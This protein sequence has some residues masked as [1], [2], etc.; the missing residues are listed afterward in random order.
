MRIRSHLAVLVVMG[1]W[2][3]GIA[4]M[5][6]ARAGDWFILAPLERHK[7]AAA[8]DGAV[9][10]LAKE[11]DWLEH[12]IDEY[13]TVVPKQPDIWGQARLTAHRAEFDAKMQDELGIFTETLQAS[14]RVSDQAFFGMAMALSKGGADAS[15]DWSKIGLEK[16]TDADGKTST[17]STFVR[18]SGSTDPLKLSLE[19][20]ARVAQM[21]R[22]LNYVNELRRI[23]EGDD[24]A[25]SPGYAMY[26]LR[27]P[28][29]VLPGKKT[30]Q[31][32]GAEITILAEPQ[33]TDDLLPTTFRNLVINDVV[34]QLSL[35][36]T[37]LLN[38]YQGDET[39]WDQLQLA[40]DAAHASL[41][42]DR[43]QEAHAGD[44]PHTAEYAQ[45]YRTQL[46]EWCANSEQSEENVD[47]AKKTQP[48]SSSA[49][50]A[51]RTGR[52]FVP[53]NESPLVSR[54]KQP[55]ALNRTE[56]V[57]TAAI[58]EKNTRNIRLAF[59][60]LSKR[61]STLSTRHSR[62]AYPPTQ[63][64]ELAGGD[65][66]LW[67]PVLLNARNSIR[68]ATQ[69]KAK[70]HLLD[71]QAFLRAELEAAYE[72]L[73]H[74]KMLSVW[75][76]CCT[77]DLVFAAR[78]RHRGGWTMEGTP[79]LS[80][81]T[82][83]KSTQPSFV[84]TW[85][86]YSSHLRRIYADEVD[87][88][89]NLPMDLPPQWEI[90]STAMVH[91]ARNTT[92]VSL[93]WAILVE[94]TL[95]N[96]R[97]IDDIRKTSGVRGCNPITAEDWPPFY[98]PRNPLDG[99]GHASCSKD[100]EWPEANAAF[101]QYVRC[102]WP[103]QVF[104]LDPITDEQNVADQYQGHRELQVAVA[105]AVANGQMSG[106]AAA[107]FVRQLD[108]SVDTIALNRTMVAFSHGTDT[109]GWR[110]YP[111]V[112]TPQTKGNLVAFYQSIAGGPT[113]KQLL[114]DRRLEPGMRECDVILL[115]PSFVPHVCI[116]TRANWFCLTNPAHKELGLHDSMKISRTYQSVRQ[117]ATQLC[118]SPL[119]RDGD[120]NRLARAVDQIDRRLPL[121]TTRVQVPYENTV[122]G[123]ELFSCGI[124]DLAP[125]LIG[126]YGEPGIFVPISSDGVP[127]TAIQVPPDTS[128]TTVFL[129]GN[130]F[131]V[132][133]T[134]V[135]AGGCLVT[136]SKL[137]S[138]QVLSVKIPSS[139]QTIEGGN[140]GRVVDVHVAT[141]YGVSVHLEIP[142]LPSA[143]TDSNTKAAKKTDSSAS[144][145]WKDEGPYQVRVGLCCDSQHPERLTLT[146]VHDRPAVPQTWI[147]K[148]GGSKIMVPM[149]GSVVI[150][151]IA[152]TKGSETTVPLKASDEWKLKSIAGNQ[153]WETSED[154]DVAAFVQKTIREEVNTLNLP[155]EIRFEGYVKFGAWPPI[156]LDNY[157]TVK[158][159]TLANNTAVAKCASTGAS[160][161]APGSPSGNQVI[162]LALPP[163][164]YRS[165]RD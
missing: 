104:T 41:L 22:Y 87:K 56:E 92:A 16:N 2:L 1:C 85:E 19:P 20:T 58:D 130:N 131:S 105:V 120:I 121:Q 162:R 42:I 108:I 11:I 154:I 165:Q 15:S 17:S 152:T 149:S 147:V 134:K 91:D 51:A 88:L 139:V 14:V 106:N 18:S 83:K 70:I 153:G 59:S 89:S 124:T 98:L 71:V 36:L 13:G 119:Y 81:Q 97:L 65:P 26:L 76:A 126:W 46:A 138:R 73:S 40:V 102:R 66:S 100:S 144:L 24:T 12:Y 4:M 127:K 109:F 96:D 164:Q 32:F 77:K 99:N 112:Q 143:T 150:Q 60:Q 57:A 128:G 123:F 3:A 156:K 37:R 80:A 7:P 161:V 27:V 151:P 63:L 107:R 157:V 155:D 53:R 129:V 116:E 38:D 33:L 64:A 50:K 61:V 45:R 23:N 110:F 68:N 35:P 115:M 21:A 31:G 136:E 125:E 114:Q 29:S 117:T 72:F 10:C 79:D 67:G 43:W 111:R 74:P 5:S 122:G 52:G 95:L 47:D 78:A 84:T 9:E 113:T 101:K 55:K 135:I 118:N 69:K 82:E 25:D 44:S 145:S 133:D 163:D 34:D 90:K 28:V 93:G 137:I 103:I 49:K 132:H 146:A 94:A 140:N 48:S 54:V 141:P 159:Q 148:N 142:A 6:A 30:Q 75:N 86:G 39:F 8:K 62:L 160:V 158:I